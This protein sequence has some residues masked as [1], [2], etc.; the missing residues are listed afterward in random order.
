MPAATRLSFI[1]AVLPA[2]E[3]AADITIAKVVCVMNDSWSALH[4]HVPVEERLDRIVNFRAI[5]P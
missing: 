2:L 4:H 1:L 5:V 3:I